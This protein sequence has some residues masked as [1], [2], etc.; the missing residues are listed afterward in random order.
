MVLDVPEALMT[1]ILRTQ[2]HAAQQRAQAGRGEVDQLLY[3]IRTTM[4]VRRVPADGSAPE[5]VCDLRMFI[6]TDERG[7]VSYEG[8]F[9]LF[10]MVMSTVLEQHIA[11]LAEAAEAE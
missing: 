9:G 1:E 10:R 4:L 8:T 5:R 6:S 2:A 11:R 3:S 7:R